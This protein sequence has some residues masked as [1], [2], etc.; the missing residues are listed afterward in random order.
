MNINKINN[1][2]STQNGILTRSLTMNFK[3]GIFLIALTLLTTTSLLAKES[4]CHTDGCVS[5]KNARMDAVIK[6]MNTYDDCINA[7]SWLQ[8]LKKVSDD[9]FELILYKEDQFSDPNI[10]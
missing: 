5:S 8:S 10:G 7:V 1:S 2:D 9:R 3:K 6:F 4:A